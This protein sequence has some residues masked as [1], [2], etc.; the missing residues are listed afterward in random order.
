[1]KLYFGGA[2]VPSHKKT[3]EQNGVSHVYL[4]YMGLR[5][6]V[7]FKRPWLLAEK[8]PASTH[9]LLD[10]GAYTVNRGV[11]DELASS[12]LVD[13]ATGYMDF[14]AKNHERVDAFTEF[15]ALPLGLDWLRTVRADFY[16]D[17]GDKFMPVWHA[18]YGVDELEALAGKYRRIAILQTA[19]GDRDLVPV[20]N[21]LASRR[22]TLFHGLAMTKPDIMAAV[23]WD[24]VGSTSWISPMQFGD[25]QIWTGSKLQRYPKAYK[26][27]GRS[28]NRALIEHIG[29]NA[30]KVIADDRAEV[31]KLTL[32]SWNQLVDD[33]NRKAPD[34]RTATD[35]VHAPARPADGPVSAVGAA[36]PVTP[37]KAP[38]AR[39]RVLLPGVDLF[40]PEG[41]EH[42]QFAVRSDNLRNC[43]TC[44]LRDRGCPGYEPGAACL[45]EMPIMIRTVSD[46]QALEN[47]L[48]SMQTQRV[49]FMKMTEDL[50]GGHVNPNLSG[51]LDRLTRMLKN[52][53][54][55]RADRFSLHVTGSNKPGEPGI[56]GSMFGKNVADAQTIEA[57][58]AADTL[59]KESLMGSVYDITEVGNER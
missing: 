58:S 5:R 26:E 30:D 17:F 7:K 34:F 25:T 12:D 43:D 31:A 1:V 8:F 18:E 3:L 50:E 21:L 20:L 48:I 55:G 54:E 53:R 22:G 19:L 23:R 44:I 10:S 42:G 14:V 49:M 38:V 11:D 24:S 52:Q 16:D 28:E 9:V 13:I 39:K 4:S 41:Q 33:L 29:L 47:G 37:L 51:E 57:P 32:W 2:E 36:Q 15:D 45:Y 6:R 59:I 46:A 27:K 35:L 40:Q 56:I